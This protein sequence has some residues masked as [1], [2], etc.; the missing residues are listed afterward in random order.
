MAGADQ[1]LHE[2]R[3]T[4]LAC[5]DAAGHTLI[6]AMMADCLARLDVQAARDAFR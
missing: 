5:A 4:A 2:A 1:Q 6:R 3:D